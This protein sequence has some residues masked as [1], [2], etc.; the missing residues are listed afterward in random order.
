MSN[1]FDCDRCDTF[2][3]RPQ[4]REYTVAKDKYNTTTTPSVEYE[5]LDLCGDCHSEL[6]EWWNA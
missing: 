1:A 4:R 3:S 2:Y 6:M 5:Q